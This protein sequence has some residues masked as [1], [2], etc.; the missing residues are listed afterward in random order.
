MHIDMIEPTET[1][2][3]VQDRAKLALG[4]SKTEA[5]L[6]ALATKNV[7][8]VAVIDKA[9]REQAHGAAM[10][11]VR[12]RTAITKVGKTARDDANKFRDAIIAEEKRL[13]E[14]IQPE[15]VRLIGLRDEWDEEQARIKREA[16]E[17]ERARILA[18]TDRIRE[19]S[20]LVVLAAGCRT[21][22][23]ASAFLERLNT[24][25]T[26]FDYAEFG[27]EADATYAACYKRIQD[28]VDAKLAEEAELAASELKRQQEA[29]ALAAERIAL[30]AERAAIAKEREAIEAAK[31]KVEPADQFEAEVKAFAAVV[32]VPAAEAPIKLSCVKVSAPF[33]TRRPTDEQIVDVLSIHYQVTPAIV[34]EWLLT[35]KFT[36]TTV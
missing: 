21:S 27:S 23:R 6:K 29:A 12:A 32:Q 8:I 13:V 19:M 14:I 30:A 28:L 36:F 20:G 11:L 15:E 16:E 3:T 5:D 26:S 9:G 1:A 22:D 2:L 17:K 25:H 33:P 4:S 24:S 31:P 10:E 18:I 35:F 7:S 34:E